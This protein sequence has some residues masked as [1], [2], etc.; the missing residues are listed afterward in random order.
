M[1]ERQNTVMKQTGFAGKMVLVPVTVP[2]TS[3]HLAG[4]LGHGAP[5]GFGL[6]FF[7][8]HEEKLGRARCNPGATEN[9]DSN[10]TN[11]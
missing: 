7:F 8:L 5:G 3:R 10:V 4:L 9:H 1:V 6:E 11:G 2:A